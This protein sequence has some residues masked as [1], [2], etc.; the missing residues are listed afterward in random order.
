MDPRPP[1]KSLPAGAA[2]EGEV[3]EVGQAPETIA[4]AGAHDGAHDFGEYIRAAVAAEGQAHAFDVS[5][6]APRSP[7]VLGL[8]RR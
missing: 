6:P 4:S 3:V 2:E 7:V 1:A 5:R 8:G